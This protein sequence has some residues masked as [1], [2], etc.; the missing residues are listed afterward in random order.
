MTM[1]PASPDQQR[2]TH[3]QETVAGQAWRVHLATVGHGKG[4]FEGGG[5][6]KG[7]TPSLE[8]GTQN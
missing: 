3:A 2:K 4:Q 7:Q 5:A 1:V 8:Q 6:A